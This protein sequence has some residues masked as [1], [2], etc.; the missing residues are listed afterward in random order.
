MTFKFSGVATALITPFIN[1]TS[2]IAP[3]I[4]EVAFSKLCRK[5]IDAGIHGLVVCGSTAEAITLSMEEQGQLIELAVHES[6]GKIPIIAGVGSPSTQSSLKLAEQAAKKGASALL[7]VTPYYNRPTPEG[8]YQHFQSLAQV[9]LPIFLYN[10]PSRTGCDLSLEV[11]ERLCHFPTIYG[12]KESSGNVSKIASILAQFGDRLCILSG[13]DALNFP[14]YCL[15]AKGSI[16]VASNLLP[17]QQVALYEHVQQKQMEQAR[18]LHTEILPMV[19]GL[20]LESNPIPIKTAL[21]VTRVIEEQFRL[22]LCSMSAKNKEILIY[23]LKQ[24]GLLK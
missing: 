8:L 3:P 12:L 9:G 13:D 1:S 21:S 10:V 22:P 18:C 5:Q 15:G 7:A 4:D 14:L 2:S 23:L 11:I 16:S 19:E 20:F 24:Q 6:K 17:K